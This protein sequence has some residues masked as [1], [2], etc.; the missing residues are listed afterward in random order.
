MI[1]TFRRTFIPDVFRESD[2]SKIHPP[3]EKIGEHDIRCS[4]QHEIKPLIASHSCLRALLNVT[5]N[6]TVDCIF[7]VNYCYIVVQ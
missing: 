4:Q 3:P 2:H 5:V 7:A 1:R 6:C